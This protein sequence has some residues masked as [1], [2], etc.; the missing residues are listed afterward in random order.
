MSEEE[1][2]KNMTFEEYKQAVLDELNKRSPNLIESNK[3]LFEKNEADLRG[4][5]EENRT[6]AFVAMAYNSPIY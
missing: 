6:P 1:Q 3:E 2:V 5:Y 4:C